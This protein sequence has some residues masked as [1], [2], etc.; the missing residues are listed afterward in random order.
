MLRWDAFNSWLLR[1]FTAM[2][3]PLHTFNSTLFCVW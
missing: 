1:G 2:A 3:F